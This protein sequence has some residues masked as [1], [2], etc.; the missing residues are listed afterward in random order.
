MIKKVFKILF[1]EGRTRKVNAI[2]LGSSYPGLFRQIGR[3][4][5]NEITI[6]P[7]PVPLR[8]LRFNFNFLQSL[9]HH[10]GPQPAT[11]NEC[12]IFL[13]PKLQARL[14]LAR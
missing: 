6:N 7:N 1:R 12:T 14:E 4:I 8:V 9:T 5:G 2:Y 3:R 10:L 13:V 11:P